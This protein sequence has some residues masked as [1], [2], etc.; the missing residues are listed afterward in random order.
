MPFYFSAFKILKSGLL[1]LNPP[2]V[3]QSQTLFP[4]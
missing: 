3:Y 1:A 2:K 4:K